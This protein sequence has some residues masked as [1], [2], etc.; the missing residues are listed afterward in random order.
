MAA[1]FELDHFLDDPTWEQ[2]DGC[3]KVDLETIAAHFSMAVP[4]PVL[5]KDLKSLVVERCLEEGIL[6]VPEVKSLTG[7]QTRYLE[8]VEPSV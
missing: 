5:K 6:V 1:C 3:R 7:S 4:K 8:A 2:L